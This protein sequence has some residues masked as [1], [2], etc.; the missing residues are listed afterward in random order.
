VAPVRAEGARRQLWSILD[1]CL[2]DRRQAWVLAS[3]GIYTQAR[4]EEGAATMGTHEALIRLATA[5]DGAALHEA[6][7]PPPT[8]ARDSASLIAVLGAS[9]TIAFAWTL[10]GLVAGQTSRY[11]SYGKLTRIL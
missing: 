2:N 10:E 9:P 8:F 1:L 5:R 4:L 6:G 11:D 3:N 7:R